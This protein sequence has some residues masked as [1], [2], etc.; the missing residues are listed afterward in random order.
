MRFGGPR[1]PLVELD[2]TSMIDVTF[3]LLIFFLVTAQMAA[4]SRGDL[5]LPVEPGEQEDRNAPAGLV[6][7]VRADGSIAV[8]DAEVGPEQLTELARRAV[9]R[10]GSRA[11]VVRADRT[12]PVAAINAVAVAL[13]A[14]GAGAFQLATQRE[15][16]R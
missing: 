3:L 4:R 16:P 9:A 11:P 15:D 10:G 2:L 5:K 7:L 6:V 13:R 8:G 12:A 14:G 1:R